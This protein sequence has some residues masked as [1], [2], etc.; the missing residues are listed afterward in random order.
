VSMVSL[1]QDP[2]IRLGVAKLNKWLAV[3][4]QY[5]ATKLANFIETG[6]GGAGYTGESLKAAI[7]GCRN[8]ILW[9]AYH[10]SG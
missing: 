1:A 2:D 6:S 8:G 4:K 5:A 3:S 7:D 9:A 10:G